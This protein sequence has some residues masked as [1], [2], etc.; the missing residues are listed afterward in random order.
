MHSLF[1]SRLHQA[2]PNLRVVVKFKIDARQE[3]FERSKFF[4]KVVFVFFPLQTNRYFALGFSL[5]LGSFSVFFVYLLVILVY[6]VQLFVLIA[7]FT[8]D[9]KGLCTYR[10]TFSQ[11]MFLILIEK[12]IVLSVAPS[13]SPS[14]FF[15]LMIGRWF[16]ARTLNTCVKNSHTAA[17]KFSYFNLQFS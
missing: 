4:F 10:V 6:M 14:F 5:L 7:F 11:S 9:A 13:L 15:F 1:R 3:I 17:I 16:H 12:W 2:P 8:F